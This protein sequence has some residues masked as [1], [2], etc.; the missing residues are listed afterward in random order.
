MYLIPLHLN[1]DDFKALQPM[2]ANQ[3]EHHSTAL[4]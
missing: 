2:T 4:G 3:T 1:V